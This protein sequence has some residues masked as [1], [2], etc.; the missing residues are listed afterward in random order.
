MSPG[1]TSFKILQRKSHFL[2]F[3]FSGRKKTS[4]KNTKIEFVLNISVIG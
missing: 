4:V 2:K 3:F 1:I